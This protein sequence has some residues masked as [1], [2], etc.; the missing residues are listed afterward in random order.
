[1]LPA[2]LMAQSTVTGTVTDKANAMP[3]PGVNVIIKGTS[4]GTSTDF[5]GKYSIEVNQ[6]EILVFSY[7]GY[8]TQE[9]EFTGQTTINV[10]LEE[11]AAQLDEV[12]L[13]GYGSTTKQDAT[14]A[15]EKVG[16]EEFNRGAIVAP[17]QLIAGKAAGVRVTSGGGAAGEGGEIRIRGGAS[18]SA[19][20]D[21]LIVIDGL[22]ID[23]R[24]GAQGSRNALNAINPADIE[25]FVVLKDASATAIYGSRASNGVILITTKKGSAN[26][27]LKV[28]YGLQASTRRVANK[29]MY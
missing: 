28:E 7:L 19:S 26:Q 5:D 6:G 15:V 17:Q 12:V 14:G 8:T 21:P 9:I 24:G 20:N 25:D 23:Q 16:D 3:L 4:R 2:T 10:P 18:L 22:P 11:D 1:M 27:P 13:I 29:V